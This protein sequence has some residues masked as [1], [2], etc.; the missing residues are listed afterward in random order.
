[1]NYSEKEWLLRTKTQKPLDCAEISDLRGMYF[2]SRVLKNY[3]GRDF[4]GCVLYKCYPPDLKGA[5]SILPFSSEEEELLK[6]TF[7]SSITSEI[8]LSGSEL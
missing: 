1:M 3:E 5:V 2:H 6:I 8:K 4:S 7:A